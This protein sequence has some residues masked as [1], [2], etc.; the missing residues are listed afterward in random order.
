MFLYA[1]NSGQHGS[2]IETLATDL[3][4][5]TSS[6][7]LETASSFTPIDLTAGTQYWLAPFAY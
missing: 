4:G 5:P 6:Y 1:D 7:A 2:P 3:S